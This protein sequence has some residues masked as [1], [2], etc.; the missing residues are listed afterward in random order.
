MMTAKRF[1]RCIPKTRSF[2]RVAVV[3]FVV[4]TANSAVAQYDAAGRYYWNPRTK[5]W[6]AASS[7]QGMMLSTRQTNAYR[8]GEKA[9]DTVKHVTREIYDPFYPC[10]QGWKQQGNHCVR[11][12]EI[13][14]QPVQPVH[15]APVP[16]VAFDSPPS[17]LYQSPPL[18]ARASRA[19]V[20]NQRPAIVLSGNLAQ[21]NAQVAAYVQSAR[22]F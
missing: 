11:R 18:P 3:L 21:R 20:P 5:Q 2:L 19:I 16:I 12:K 1:L 15:A 4:T 13:A 10:Q 6:Y 9:I 14:F 7:W 8:M 17:S 22:G